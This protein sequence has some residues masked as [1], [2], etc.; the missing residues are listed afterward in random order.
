M[1]PS[2][3]RVVTCT[4]FDLYKY[5]I[6]IIGLF[7]AWELWKEGR[8][9][10]IIDQTLGDL[11]PNDVLR[12]I[13]VGLLCVQENPADRPSMSDVVSMFTNEILQLSAPSQPA[14]FTGRSPLE[15]GISRNKLE[16]CSVNN[17]SVSEME[18]R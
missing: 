4:E 9:L 16:N 14:F 10:E 15:S 2:R 17:A 1:I 11:C 12:C 5:F 3:T 18:A 6:Y 13:H 7:Q 8:A